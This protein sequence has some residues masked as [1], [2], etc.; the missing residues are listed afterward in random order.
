MSASGGNIS[1]VRTPTPVAIILTLKRRGCTSRVSLVKSLLNF[2]E[3]INQTKVK[4]KRL[5]KQKIG[6]ILFPFA[7][8]KSVFYLCIKGAQPT[9][10]PF[11]N[12]VVLQLIVLMEN[13]SGNDVPVEIEIEIEG[14]N[15]NGANPSGFKSF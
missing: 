12:V 1:S 11:E 2:P 6:S 8:R 4:Q 14:E 3:K 7:K 9:T 15:E 5:K 13:H 10:L